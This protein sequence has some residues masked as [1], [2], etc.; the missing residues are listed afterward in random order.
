MPVR[1]VAY[2]YD[3]DLLLKDAG[4]VAADAA[5]TVGGSAKVVDLGTGRVDGVLVIDVTAVEIA[6]NDERYIVVLQGCAASNFASGVENLGSVEFG[7]TEVRSGGAID[8]TTGRYYLKF[9]NEQ[10][11]TIYRYARVYTDVSGTIATGISFS[12]WIAKEGN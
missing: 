1:N 2:T 9:T 12:A 11:G 7:A 3:N 6:S 4:L 5:A 10:N 8:S